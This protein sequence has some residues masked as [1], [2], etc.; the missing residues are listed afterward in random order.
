MNIVW[1]IL[2]SSWVL[3]QFY[4]IFIFLVFLA[5]TKLVG[6]SPSHLESWALL[7]RSTSLDPSSKIEANVQNY[8]SPFEF[9]YMGVELWANHMGWKWGD[10]GNILG[11]DLREPYGNI[12]GTHWELGKKQNQKECEKQP[13]PQEKIWTPHEC[14][15]NLLIGCMKLVF[16]NLFVNIFGLG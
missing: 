11:N 5:G 6:P 9:L 8:C 4:F 3:S 10:I 7:N 15:L 14:M 12:I 2:I 1:F 16:P 13:P